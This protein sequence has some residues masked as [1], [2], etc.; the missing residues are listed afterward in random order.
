ML[1]F[2]A[3]N[4]NLPTLIGAGIV[5]GGTGWLLWHSH[6]S[7]GACSSCGGC[8]GG[9]SCGGGCTGCSGHCHPENH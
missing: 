2:L 6:K 5:F 9:C 3:L 7:G 1:E 4:F 8:S